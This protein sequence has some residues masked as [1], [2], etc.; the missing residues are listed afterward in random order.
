L[1]FLILITLVTALQ[2]L[3]RRLLRQVIGPRFDRW[4]ILALVL[5]HLPLALFVGF[6]LS[7]MG[8]AALWFRPL[9]RAGAYFQI[10]TFMDLL[11]WAGASLVWRWT[12]LW[13]KL[14]AAPLESPERRRFLRQT[15]AVGVALAG[16]SLARGTQEARADPDIVRQELHFPDLPGALDGLRIV[17]VSDLHAGPLVA[18]ELVQRWRRMAEAERPELLLVTGD[19]VDSLPEEAGVVAEAFKDFRAPLGRYAILGNHDYFTDPRPI[20]RIL[21]GIGFQF[22]EN[23]SALVPRK[24]GALALVGLQDPMARHGRF[25]DV[26]FGPGPQPDQAVRGLPE[27]SWRLCLSHRPSDWRLAR[28]TGAALTLSGHTHGGQVNLIPGVS[29]AILLGEYTMG[30]YRKDGQQLYVNRGLG[31]V[32]LPLRIGAPPEITVI[33]LRRG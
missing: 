20:W 3:H 5:I 6:R 10:L 11:V 27:G 7:G 25:R 2:A 1:T 19:M 23:S 21:E 4:V 28:R 17:Q 13:R 30:L 24:G 12:H 9:A 32:G 18:P 29:S 26:V 15:S 16:Y 8:Q 22:L 33:T 14:A 31:V